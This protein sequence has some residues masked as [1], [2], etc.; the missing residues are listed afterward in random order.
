M[1]N[2]HLSRVARINRRVKRRAL[3]AE[4]ETNEMTLA[5]AGAALDW[6]VAE[7]A[8]WQVQIEEK[9]KLREVLKAMQPPDAF[10]E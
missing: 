6:Q 7:V 9:L 2:R 1:N 10:D 3:L 5:Q 4:I 8:A